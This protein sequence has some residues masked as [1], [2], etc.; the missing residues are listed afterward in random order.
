MMLARILSGGLLLALAGELFAQAPLLRDDFD[1]TAIDSSLWRVTLPF[2]NPPPSTAVETNGNLVLFRRGVL[3]SRG[4]F[5]GSLDIQGKFRFTGE[6]DALSIVFRSDLS[7]T[8]QA[9]R[10]GVQAALQEATG[11]VFLIPEP[12]ASTPTSGAFMIPKN[13]DVTFRI[14]DN[15]D[16]VRLY[17][18]DL[19]LP[20]MSVTITNRRGGHVSLYNSLNTAGRAQ[21]DRFSI[22]PL[23]T[24]V[25]ID[26]QLTHEGPVRKTS[27]AQVKLQPFYTNSL[28]F[29]TL[30]GT[31]PSFV[32]TEYDGPFTI[33]ASAI[34]RAV[35]Y[36]ADFLESTESPAIEVQVLPDVVLTNETPG[37]GIIQFS[38]PGPVYSS[39]TL[40][41]MVAMPAAGW[42]FMRWDGAARGTALSN[43]VVMTNHLA[44]RAVFG[45]T[46]ALSVIGSGQIQSYPAGP[47]QAYGSRVRLMA[48]PSPGSYF[49]RWANGVTGNSSPGTLTVTNATPGV[50]ALFSALVGNQVSLT[51]QVEGAGT[52]AL[53][54][55][56]H[57][58]TNGQQVALL[59]VPDAG[60]VFLGWTGDA[61]GVGN[62]LTLLMDASKTVMARF[63]P[64]VEFRPAESHLGSDGFLISIKSQPGFTFDLQASPNLVEWEPVA[65]LTNSSGSLFY[66]HGDATNWPILFYRAVG[67]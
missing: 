36:R 44:V 7:V 23:R 46:P 6:S 64:A 14:T 53:S 51:T 40:V 61:S 1:G 4:T 57:V 31:E 25:F 62:P 34:I 65:T 59:A 12:F 49:F 32:S 33:G 42:Q 5:E 48:L 9:E 19:F 30:D 24:C 13:Q 16:L 29:Y 15:G 22:H 26:N 56:M 8:N 43:T 54:P 37:G 3:D 38:P 60:H 50:S 17:F 67:P 47:V 2:A 11:R 10:R 52:L 45:T 28:M 21:V 35:S 66:R 39:N 58:F 18:D 55:A 20:V 63:G 41:S 27:A